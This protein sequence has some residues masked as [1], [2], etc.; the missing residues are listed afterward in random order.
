MPQPSPDELSEIILSARFG[1][2]DDVKLFVETYGKQALADARD[3]SGNSVLHMASA[4][5][6]QGWFVLQNSYS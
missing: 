5:G 6:H 1:D 2:I 4:N 3:E